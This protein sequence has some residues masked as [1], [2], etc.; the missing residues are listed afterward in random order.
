MNLFTR[1]N[2]RVGV[3]VLAVAYFALSAINIIFPLWLQ[4]TLGYTATWAGL[5]VAPVGLLA[6]VAAPI[7]G[8]N[9]NR[10]NL[11]L[12]ASFA[13]CVFGFA[14]FWTAT[15]NEQ[16]SFLQFAKPRFFQ[17]MGLSVFFLTLNQIILSGIPSRDLASASGVSNFIRTMSGSIAT[18]VTV[19]IWNRRTDYHHA[20]LTEHIRNAAGGWTQYQG[21]LS[22]QGING[23]GAFQFVDQLI[24]SQA[25]TLAINDV[26]FALGCIFFLLVPFI[27]LAKPPFG[28][29]ALR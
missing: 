16:A 1:R 22:A 29:R 10:I 9:M 17:G 15:L 13:F 26:F 28:A 14:V 27:W 5:A 3:G 11:R 18:A 23:T 7:V 2:F 4:T 12:A 19:W 24:G 6:L 25:A 20:V 21:Q 8:R